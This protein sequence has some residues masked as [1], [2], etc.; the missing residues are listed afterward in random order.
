MAVA[1]RRRTRREFVQGAGLG[2]IALLLACERLP[3]QAQAPAEVARIGFLA[4][5]SPDD[6]ALNLDAFRQGLA[7]LNLI[8]GQNVVLE[9]RYGEGQLDRISDLARE[10]VR[11]PVAV[12]VARGA[13]PIRA[14][15]EASNITPIVMAAGGGDPVGTGLVSSL[16]RPGGNVTGLSD[17]RTELSAKRLQL[18][19][20][21]R[22]GLSRVGFMWTPALPDRLQE[23]EDTE[24]AART[25]GV[26]IHALEVATAN[27]LDGAFETALGEHVDALL[28]Q[29]N[30]LLNTL[31]T[32]AAEFALRNRLPTAAQD[33]QL[34]VA[35]GL[36]YYGPNLPDQLRRTAYYVDRILKGANPA[37]L[38]IEQP[39]TFDCVI[40]L[41]T[42][43]ALDLTIPQH[44]L[45]QATE[46]LQ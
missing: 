10:L 6:P 35:G 38:P 13:A 5:G 41:Q 4:S 44:V 21:I 27:D 28:I 37:E 3:G 45:L 29:V 18:L 32:R 25:L 36:M 1:T 31:R 16:A 11:L 42:A 22:P 20:D 9:T 8:E 46:V 15:K 33:R 26:G 43:R 23:L 40:N 14:A 17:L 39:T 7:E 30:G 12:L 34:V 24:A 2:G 19:T